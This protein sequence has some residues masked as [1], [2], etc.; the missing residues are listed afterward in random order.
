[1]NGVLLLRIPDT[2]N[3][4]STAASHPSLAVAF[5]G[6]IS[7]QPVTGANRRYLL[8]NVIDPSAAVPADFRLATVVTNNGR[9]IT[10]AISQRSDVALTI[11]TPTGAVQIKS[12]EYR[13]RKDF[14]KVHDA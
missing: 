9:V 3:R 6:R 1:M 4:Y 13:Y 5:H 14:T 8:S 12:E 10:G 7:T 2:A 11:Q